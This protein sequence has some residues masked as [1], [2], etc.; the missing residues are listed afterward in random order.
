MAIPNKIF[1][2]III[3]GGQAGLSVAYF[4]KRSKLNYLIL[5]A[6]GN[7]GGSWLHTWDSLK[8]FS[9]SQY[10]SLSGWQMPES[11]NEYPCRQEFI[12]YLKAYEKRYNFSI[13]RNTK[14]TK[15]KNKDGIF[16]IETNQGNFAETVVSATGTAKNPFIPSFPKRKDYQGVQLHS[17]DYRNTKKFKGKK[18]LVIGGGNSGA[19]I[20][21]ELSKVAQTKWVTLEEPTFL[22]EEIDGRYLFQQANSSYFNEK[23][24]TEEKEVSLSDIVQVE[25]VK[26]GLKRNI[27]DA[28]RPFD[29]FYKDGVIWQDGEKETFDAV[30]WCTGFNANLKHL[31]PLGIIKNGHIETKNTRSIKYPKLWLVGYGNWTGFASATIYGVGKTARNTAK[32]IK[33]HFDV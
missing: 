12:D 24:Q 23:K 21:A 7:S 1:D 29:S 32:E 3:G 10:S 8:L 18:I 20:L 25:I 4:L 31:N 26:N 5:D 14:V 6:E 27:Y 2:C 33:A 15:V 11:K 9:P 30:I 17:V 19:Q 28:L 22:P 16:K 13:Q